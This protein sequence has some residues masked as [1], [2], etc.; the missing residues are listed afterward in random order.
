MFKNEFAALNWSPPRYFLPCVCLSV[1]LFL[2]LSPAAEA[3]ARTDAAPLV[4]VTRPVAVAAGLSCRCAA[5]S[6]LWMTL[7]PLLETLLGP[8]PPGN[9]R[10]RESESGALCPKPESES[11]PESL[12]QHY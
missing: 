10:S 4:R 12:Y 8:G 1:R 9:S 5:A 7:T 3:V 6:A 11:T 2:P